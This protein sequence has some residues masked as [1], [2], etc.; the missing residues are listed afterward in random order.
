[1][2]LEIIDSQILPK[3]LSDYQYYHFHKNKWKNCHFLKFF[4][5]NEDSMWYFSFNPNFHNLIS[6]VNKL[7]PTSGI[8]VYNRLQST[9]LNWYHSTEVC[10][11][12]KISHIEKYKK[13]KAFV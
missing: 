3:D 9:N 1:M 13:L 7:Q 6:S 4:R 12:R 10:L 8:I 11:L 2:I 5:K